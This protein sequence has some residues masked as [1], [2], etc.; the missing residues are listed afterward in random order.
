[1]LTLLQTLL[2]IIFLRKGPEVL[3]R[4]PVIL[5][6]VVALLLLSDITS[7][8]AVDSYTR[9]TFILD[10]ILGITSVVA[11]A[12]I[13]H[14]AE[15]RQRMLQTLSAIIGCGAVLSFVSI[16]LGALATGWFDA[17]V[18]ETTIAFV[19][20]WSLAVEAHIIARAI[21]RSWFVGFV[22]AL[23]VLAMQLFL[24][25]ALEPMID[26]KPASADVARFSES[27]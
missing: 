9:H 6:I 18:V 21:D 5:V 15:R 4:M 20:L 17:D 27:V 23:A 12:A 2:E 3:P 26:P 1:M 25:S 19:W 14:A 24:L 22:A 7:L 8:L 11:F 10:L 13:I 16:L